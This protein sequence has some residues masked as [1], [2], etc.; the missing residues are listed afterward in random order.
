MN[1]KA[2]TKQGPEKNTV[3]TSELSPHTPRKR[4][5]DP[6]TYISFSV[7]RTNEAA[8]SERGRI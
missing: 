4:A 2:T 1:R 8:A 7:L 6:Q 3:S 5:D